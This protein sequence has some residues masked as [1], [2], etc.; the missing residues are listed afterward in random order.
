MASESHV[1]SMVRPWSCPVYMPRIRSGLST[2][3]EAR[4]TSN[5]S[6]SVVSTPSRSTPRWLTV[7]TKSGRKDVSTSSI[8][9]TN[10]SRF[11]SLV[12]RSR[13]MCSTSSRSHAALSSPMRKYWLVSSSMRGRDARNF[14]Q[15]AG[16]SIMSMM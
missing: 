8:L 13:S 6:R 4:G 3:Q 5:W 14:G 1:K 12:P 11:I 10:T 2:N 15:L 9:A 7:S 16:E